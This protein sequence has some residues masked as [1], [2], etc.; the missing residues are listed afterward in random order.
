[1]KKTAYLHILTLPLLFILL[2]WNATPTPP[3]K[4]VVHAVLF[5]SPSCGHCYKVIT[6][7]LPPLTEKYGEQFVIAGADISDPQ[8]SRLFQAVLDHYQMD[9]WGVPFLV[10]GDTCLIGSVDIPEQLP[11]LIEKYLAEVGWI[12]RRSR[13]FARRWQTTRNPRRLRPPSPRLLQRK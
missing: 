6:E 12:G 7:V 1:M 8:A 13:P 5:Y 3:A 9:S 10:V 11:G 4:P 2:P